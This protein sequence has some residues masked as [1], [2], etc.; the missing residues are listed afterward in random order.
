MLLLPIP[1]LSTFTNGSKAKLTVRKLV[2]VEVE[3]SNCDHL[4]L[5]HKLALSTNADSKLC[6]QTRYVRAWGGDLHFGM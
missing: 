1:I 3:V 5:C 6:V 2:T 4:C